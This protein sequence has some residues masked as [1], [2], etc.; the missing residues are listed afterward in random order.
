MPEK[1]IFLDRDGVINKKAAVHEYIARWEN[2]H[3]LPDVPEA[4]RLMN[5]HGY[6]VAVVTNQRGIA[7]GLTTND[8]VERL[9]D[10]MRE[11]L[12][13][14]GACISWVFHCPHDYGEC[15][16]RKPNTGLLRRVEQF[17]DVDKPASWMVGDSPIDI[18][19]GRTYGV[20]TIFIGEEC[21]SAAYCCTSLSE[22]AAL[23][24]RVKDEC[25][26]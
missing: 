26:Y 7:L 17:A 2:F 9:H 20:N 11:E 3:F 21:E 5:E 18:E 22:A 15:D 1:I 19:A 12:L 14:K 10:K 16:C 13:K 4:I 6:K 24:T 25:K 8:E 23:I